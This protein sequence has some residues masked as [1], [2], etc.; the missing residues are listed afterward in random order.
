MLSV[1]ENFFVFLFSFSWRNSI[2]NHIVT[3]ANLN[4]YSFSSYDMFSGAVELLTTGK[5]TA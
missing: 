5:K 1:L 4:R 2:V 3:K